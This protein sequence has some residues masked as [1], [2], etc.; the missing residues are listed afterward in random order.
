MSQDVLIEWSVTAFIF[1]LLFISIL[2][3][4]RPQ[5]TEDY[6][7][8]DSQDTD[9]ETR[10]EAEARAIIEECWPDEVI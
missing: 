6:T 1:A 7:Y 9:V 3:A 10:A 2:M 5:K 4:C 8:P